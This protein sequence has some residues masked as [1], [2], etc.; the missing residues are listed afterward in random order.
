ML[1]QVPKMVRDWASMAPASLW[2]SPSTRAEMAVPASMAPF[3]AHLHGL[4]D[5]HPI[6]SASISPPEMP[7]SAGWGISSA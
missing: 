6:F 7:A 2:S 1:D 5:I 3:S 4:G